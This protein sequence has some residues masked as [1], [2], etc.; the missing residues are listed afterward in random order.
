[1]IYSFPRRRGF[2]LI[3]VMITVSILAILLAVAVPNWIQSRERANARTCQKQ[4][5]TIRSAK[6][7][8][9]MARNLGDSATITM[10]DLVNDGWLRPGI[11]CPE[12]FSYVVGA[13]N[14][15]PTCSSGLSDHVI[16]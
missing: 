3:E 7:S 13:V 6:E 2:T 10:D 12:G 15:D 8:Y 9:V 4:L 14:E 5:Q 11:S 16:N 1:M